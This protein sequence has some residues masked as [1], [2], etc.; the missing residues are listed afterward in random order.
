MWSRRA[1]YAGS[2]APAALDINGTA[3]V[4]LVGDTWTLDGSNKVVSW[5]DVTGHGNSPTPATTGPVG[6]VATQ[7]GH[8]MARGDA[9]AASRMNFPN[10]G[11]AFGASNTIWC[12]STVGAAL[13]CLVGWTGSLGLLTNHTFKWEWFNNPNVQS[14]DNSASGVHLMTAVQ[15]DATSLVGYFDGTQVFS[16]TPTVALSGKSLLTLFSR[17]GNDLFSGADIGEVGLITSALGASDL[18][19]LNSQVKTF[20]GL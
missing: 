15:V 8:H 19:S 5:T 6:N 20:W 3:A 10:T 17:S 1:L 18:A 4:R 16:V 2:V 14:F 9:T 13:G 11:V 7:N 12:V